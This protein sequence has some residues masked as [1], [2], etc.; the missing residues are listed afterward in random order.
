MNDSHHQT[1]LKEAG[2]GGWPAT[3]ISDTFYDVAPSDPVLVARDRWTASGQMSDAV[4]SSTE[5]FVNCQQ[6]VR[7]GS[8]ERTLVWKHP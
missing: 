4:A 6:P 7:A 2:I 5:G 8:S 3:A 1:T